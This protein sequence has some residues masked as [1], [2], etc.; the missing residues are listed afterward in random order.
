MRRLTGIFR[1]MGDSTY[2]TEVCDEPVTIE[3]MARDLRHLIIHLG[4][5][6]VALLGYSM[7][8]KRYTFQ[9]TWR[10]SSSTFNA[11]I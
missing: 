5:K 2:A 9:W 6:R 8:G 11:D 10:S 7:G 3:S 4:W 1:G